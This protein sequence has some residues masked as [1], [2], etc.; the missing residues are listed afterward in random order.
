MIQ[1]KTQWPFYSLHR[2]KINKEKHGLLNP[3]SSVTPWIAAHFELASS[4]DSLE[5]LLV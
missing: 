2:Q 3:P 5:E 1:N 4:L